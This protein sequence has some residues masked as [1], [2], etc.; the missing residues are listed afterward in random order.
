MAEAAPAP[1]RVAVGS[2]NPVKLAAV[3]QAFFRAFPDRYIA[4]AG[5]DVP[6][7]VRD[8][9]WGHEETWKG[10][11]QRARGALL[12]ETGADYAVG[13]EG[14][15]VQAGDGLRSVAYVAIR[16]SRDMRGSLE[17]TA[18]FKLPPRVAR[19]LFGQEPGHG[20]LELGAACDLVFNETNSKQ[21]G[22]TVG[23]VTRGLLDR[24]AYYEHAI[25]CALAP[26]LH[27]DSGLY[28]YA[29]AAAP[30]A[31]PP[32]QL[33][34]ALHVFATTLAVVDLLE[35]NKLKAGVTLARD[36][37][38]A[39]ERLLPGIPINAFTWPEV[40]RMV[41][42]AKNAG[43]APKQR[44]VAI[45]HRG[46]LL[47]QLR[48]GEC[49]VDADEVILDLS[50]HA[51]AP[52]EERGGLDHVRQGEGGDGRAQADAAANVARG[53]REAHGRECGCHRVSGRD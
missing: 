41:I 48:V 8:Q 38:T 51:K 32:S 15:V 21:Q 5:R 14:G 52:L 19:L 53:G 45:I 49:A 7:G 16:R 11:T 13:I 10:A 33:S 39:A 3:R 6:S 20:K 26:F 28:N 18:S 35:P 12:A 43:R 30:P 22:G 27:D 2:K 36:A 50:V 42:A 9:P 29:V 47:R 34:T 1:L 44:E 37:A 40:L 4:F 24:T 17:H 31:T 23:A 46:L 25:V